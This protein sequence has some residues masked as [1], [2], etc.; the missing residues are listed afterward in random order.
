MAIARA[1]TAL[2]VAPGMYVADEVRRT[3]KD[4]SANRST[5]VAW[6]AKDSLGDATKRSEANISPPPQGMND[7]S[8][9]TSCGVFSYTDWTNDGR[10]STSTS[11]VTGRGDD[12]LT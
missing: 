2:A 10:K 12:M 4:G 1:V 3:C 7:T 5:T 6:R 9:R 11:G 8:V